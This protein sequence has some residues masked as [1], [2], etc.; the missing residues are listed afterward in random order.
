MRF[1]I[2]TGAVLFL[3][4]GCSTSLH[5]NY[6]ILDYAPNISAAMGTYDTYPFRA[7]VST[8]DISSTYDRSGIVIRSSSH[9]L[10]YSQNDLWPIRPQ[11]AIQNLLL[12]HLLKVNVF[13]EVK[14]EFLDVRPDYTITA[15]IFS[16]EM[17]SQEELNRADIEMK[18]SM[19]DNATETVVLT[20]HFT[21]F[22]KTGTNNMSYFA[23]KISDILREENTAFIIKIIK[24]LK[25]KANEESE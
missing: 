22:E 9:Q 12:Q 20:H 17:Y 5:R 4:L 2:L 19:K 25:G 15:N 13:A 18:L 11:D 21:R 7:E 1:T 3:V 10:R 14:K 16:I 23:K 6:Y 8:F 24:Y